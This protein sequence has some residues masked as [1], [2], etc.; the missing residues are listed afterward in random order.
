MVT[1]ADD[2][3]HDDFDPEH[4]A[5]EAQRDAASATHGHALLLVVLCLAA[6]TLLLAKIGQ[7]GLAFPYWDEWRFA[8]ILQKVYAGKAGFIDFWS[9]HNEHRILF[10]RVVMTLLARA[11]GWNVAWELGASVVFAIGT[12][13]SVLAIAFRRAQ[14]LDF[15]LRCCIAAVFSALIFSWTQNENWIWG[16]QCN[17]MLAMAA[18]A[19]CVATLSSEFRYPVRI[20]LGIALSTVATYSYANGLFAWPAMLLLVWDVRVAREARVAGVLVWLVAAGLVAESY[21]FGYAKPSV[22]PSPLTA[23]D[24]PLLFVQFLAVFLGA[25]ISTLFTTPA[26][27]G[28]DVAPPVLAFLPGPLAVVGV[29]WLAWRAWRGGVKWTVLAPWLTLAL[30]SL[31]SAVVASA[32]RCGFGL[33][34]ALTSRYITVTT[35]LWIALV[36][37]ALHQLARST[38]AREAR[39]QSAAVGL[40]AVAII[41]S[42]Y[43][44]SST[45][46]G[47]EQRCHWKQMGWL[48]IT[49]GYPAPLFLNDLSDTP[50]ALMG[51]LL[52]WLQQEKLCGL[53]IPVEKPAQYAPLFANDAAQLLAMGLVPQAQTYLK[54][55]EGIDPALPEL[56]QL[57]LRM[58]SASVPPAPR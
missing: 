28:V 53:G 12:Y 39:V 18:I 27:H 29:A 36:A 10:P 1:D 40:T 50:D 54:V 37:L 14:G 33:G 32:G 7:F 41:T 35:P 4:E 49:L 17:V 25:P 46:A 13:A 21:F 51:N 58:E 45:S 47:Y 57:R 3:S 42:V 2:S 52:P 8:E 31:G 26:W 9:Q 5:E 19:G 55:A 20:G 34:Q 6:P 23:L 11:S 44:A 24:H 48:A 15:T 38:F 56:T 43:G 30:F 16:F 22:S